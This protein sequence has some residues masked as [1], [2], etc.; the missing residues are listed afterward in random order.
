M[1]VETRS[2]LDGRCTIY[3]GDCIETMRRMPSGSVDCVVTSPPYWGLRDYGVDG[4][5]GLEPTLGQHIA[6]MV[7]VFTAVWRILKPQGT[8]WLNYGDCYAAAPNGKSAEAYKADGS[9]DRTFRDKPFSTV[10][11]IYQADR[12]GDRGVRGNVHRRAAGVSSPGAIVARGYLKPKDLC[13]IPNRLAI[14]LQEAGW[15]VRSEI[16][17]HK[18]NPMPESVYDRPTTAH[19]KVFLLTKGEDYFYDHEA[20]REPVTGGSH[21]RKAGPNSRQNIDRVP[22]S[23]KFAAEG[24]AMVKAKRSFAEGTADLVE[25]RN[26][27]NVWTI[28]PRAFREAHFA[29]FPPAL[30][31]RCIKAGTPKTVCGCCGVDSGCGPIC[32]TFDR[33]PGTVFDPFGGAGTVGLV[34]EQLGL[35]SILVELNPEYADI[36]VR[37]IEGA[38][39]PKDE[40]A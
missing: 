10:G 27:R 3:V 32:E 1:T 31:E 13:M 19:E 18:P 33:V 24:D 7:E 15:W 4:Q 40:A 20:I 37:R 28:A 9:D 14:A 22:R 30:A 5:I 17:W 6:V 12:H 23:R 21:A 34:A 8:V 26:A 38:Q 35:R 11:P 39:K 2:I 29:T 16:I 36:A 25:T